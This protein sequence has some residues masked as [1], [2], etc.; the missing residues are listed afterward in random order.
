LW[1]TLAVHIT[2][3]YYEMNCICCLFHFKGI[4]DPSNN[5]ERISASVQVY[6]VFLYP[7]LALHHFCCFTSLPTFTL[8]SFPLN[9]HW[10]FL[11]FSYQVNS[12]I[13]L[14]PYLKIIFPTEPDEALLSAFQVD[15]VYILSRNSSF[16]H[17]LKFEICNNSSF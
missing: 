16:V 3:N 4:I 10:N 12:G 11:I 5:C 2:C 15:F 7:P 13:R 14:G 17:E 9:S 8:S 1:G 6:F